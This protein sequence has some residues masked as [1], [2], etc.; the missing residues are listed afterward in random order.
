M[1]LN[2]AAAEVVLKT[3]YLPAIREQLN[4]GNWLLGQIEKNSTDFEGDDAVWAVHVSRNSGVGARLDDEDLPAAGKQGYAKGRSQVKHLY[5]R[6]QVTGPTMRAMKSNRGSFTRAVDSESKGVVTDTKRD[7]SRQLYGTSN[8]VIAATG[9]TS[10]VNLIVLAASTPKSAL[11]QLREG[12]KVDIGTVGSPTSQAANRN[13]TA[14]D[15][16]NHTITVDGAVV[17]TTTS[18][19]VFRQGAGGSG[20]NQREVTGLQTIVSNADDNLFGIDTGDN[21]VWAATVDASGGDLSDDLLEEVLDNVDIASGEFPQIA[22]TTHGV[23]RT[24]AAGLKDNKRFNDTVVLK[25]GFKAASITTPAG[26]LTLMRDRDA[27]DGKLFLLN[28]SHLTWFEQSDWEFMDDDGAVLNRVPNRD[29]YEA[30]LYK[31]AELATDR[32]NAHA[33][34]TGLSE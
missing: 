14:V 11:R 31:D 12:Y 10:G 33:I 9:V 29:A 25:G 19:F 30:T 20:A 2:F 23:I 26:E 4:T 17:T 15:I 3:I 5:G 8:G 1:A 28:T 6:I 22:V 7:M 34:L 24:Y 27:P 21:P 16:A 32:R 13:V 18:H